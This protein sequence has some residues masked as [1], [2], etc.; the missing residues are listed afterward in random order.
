M[1]RLTPNGPAPIIF[2]TNRERDSLR[3]ETLNSKPNSDECEA[4]RSGF[5]IDGVRLFCAPSRT[6]E[7]QFE[8]FSRWQRF[9]RCKDID[10]AL[11]VFEGLCQS[12]SPNRAH[13][14]RLI[15]AVRTIKKDR[16]NTLAQWERAV[17]VT[18]NQGTDS[19]GRA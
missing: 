16:Y 3:Q 6:N 11:T 8:V 9:H 2:M 13:A 10:E 19:H 12:E 1:Q 18:A 7:D 14:R 4:V 17:I 5:S 15:T